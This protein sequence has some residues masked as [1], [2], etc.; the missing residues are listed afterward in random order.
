MFEHEKYTRTGEFSAAFVEHF[1]FHWPYSDREIFVYNPVTNRYEVSRIFLEYAYNF[2]N[3]TMRPTFFKKF[4][5]MQYDI[6][7][8]EETLDFH[9]ASWTMN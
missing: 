5:E 4:P 7:A 2:K 1:D 6:A 8:T 3:W 9:Q